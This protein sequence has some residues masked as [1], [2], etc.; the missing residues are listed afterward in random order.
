MPLARDRGDFDEGKIDQGCGASPR[1]SQAI[2]IRRSAS[3]RG[4][5]TSPRSGRGRKQVRLRLVG[6]VVAGRLDRSDAGG[7][8][9]HAQK[10]NVAEIFVPLVIIDRAQSGE[11]RGAYTAD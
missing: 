1:R 11:K 4:P 10:E 2:A 8:F 5:K 6:G 7:G 9:A 3:P